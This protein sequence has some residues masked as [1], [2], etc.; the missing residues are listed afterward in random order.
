MGGALSSSGHARNALVRHTMRLHIVFYPAESRRPS[1]SMAPGTDYNSKREPWARAL[2]GEILLLPL[3]FLLTSS[4]T[5]RVPPR[6]AMIA[7]ADGDQQENEAIVPSLTTC[8]PR[9]GTQLVSLLSACY[10]ICTIPDCHIEYQSCRIEYESW[11][12]EYAT[13]YIEYETCCIEYESC[14]IE[15]ID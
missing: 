10:R 13:C 6:A 8:W 12:I 9:V 3:P 14:F 5:W 11:C 1:S 2:S 4:G 15:C 7:L